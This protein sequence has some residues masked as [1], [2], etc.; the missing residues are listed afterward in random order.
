[1]ST[2]TT[3]S[4]A[5]RFADS[6]IWYCYLLLIFSASFVNQ[7]FSSKAWLLMTVGVYSLLSL[8]AFS[9]SIGG[10]CNWAALRSARIPLLFFGLS[11]VYLCVQQFVPFPTAAHH[12]LSSGADAPDWFNSPLVWSV[13]PSKTRILA[14]SE[15]LMLGVMLLS[16]AL[17]SSR[18]RLVQFLYVIASVC[19]VHATVGIFTK[20]G[21]IS[22]VDLKSIDGHFSAA[23]GWF[24]NR[25]HYAAFV[26]LTLVG[27]LALQFKL[28]LSSS[29]RTTKPMLLTQLLSYRVLYL[30]GILAAILALVLSESRSGFLAIL[31]SLMIV[32][33]ALGS[34]SK[35][36]FSRRLVIVPVLSLAVV[37]LL[38]FGGDLLQRFGLGNAFL[39]ERTEQW[40]I[41]WGA[42]QAEWL[43]GYGGNSYTEVFQMN[44]DNSG[45]RE[46]LYDQAHNDYLH[47][48]L[49]QGLIGLL[50]W[51]VFLVFGI[52]SAVRGST[53]TPSTLVNA[54]VLAGTIVLVAALIQSL[55]G[56]NLHIIN[57]RFYFF[58]IMA[59]IIATP[60]IS[61]RKNRANSSILV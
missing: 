42:I 33:W 45:L 32:V 14:L 1:M 21:G 20:F 61:Q 47:I 16:L 25:N 7:F 39:G 9:A 37:L 51:L 5:H 59:L 13:V 30:L 38:Y 46:V 12:I 52:R 35:R 15:V 49:E 11:L 31:L 4:P 36:V 24:V 58:A 56:F 26:S 17:I 53:K 23:R 22:L 50:L 54:V 10:H 57:I 18:Q 44:R 60:T 55:V 40:S 2:T 6:L 41:T 28:L 27:A 8:V 19:F 3:R 29:V 48:W 43:F 34:T